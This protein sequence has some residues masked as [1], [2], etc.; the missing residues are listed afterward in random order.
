M[1]NY[2]IE[3]DQGQGNK[4]GDHSQS[5]D[6]RRKFKLILEQDGK[7]G[8]ESIEVSESWDCKHPGS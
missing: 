6:K 4:Y 7:F 8:F 1:A 5:L 3:Q 2:W